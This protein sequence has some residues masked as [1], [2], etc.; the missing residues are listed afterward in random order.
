MKKIITLFI[1]A[2]LLVSTTAFALTEAQ[3]AE[4]RRQQQAAQRAYQASADTHN[5]VATQAGTYKEGAEIVKDSVQAVTR[6][7]Y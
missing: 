7:E 5:E 1:I 4:Q 3:R 2:V 6:T